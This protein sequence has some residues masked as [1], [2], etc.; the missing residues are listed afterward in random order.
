MQE[1]CLACQR[2]ERH[3]TAQAHF[4][5]PQRTPTAATERARQL[6]CLE[7]VDFP[8]I[9]DERKHMP[10]IGAASLSATYMAG[11]GRRHATAKVD[12]EAKIVERW[13]EPVGGIQSKAV[14]TVDGSPEAG[15]RGMQRRARRAHACAS[16]CAGVVKL[17]A[18]PW[19]TVAMR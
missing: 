13:E 8:R 1:Q 19:R 5:L 18:G 14:I 4:S 16:L 6:C 10:I 17:S 15:G 2:S 11:I 9:T 3:P 7:S 12:D